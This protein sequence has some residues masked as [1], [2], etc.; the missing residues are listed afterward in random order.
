MGQSLLKPARGSALGK[1]AL[2]GLVTYG[3]GSVL[4]G[5]ANTAGK[6]ASAAGQVGTGILNTAKQA[7]L[8][9]LRGGVGGAI[10]GGL[11]GSGLLSANS[12]L[13]DVIETVAN[14]GGGKGSQTPTPTSLMP[15]ASTDEE[16]QRLQAAAGQRRPTL[17]DMYLGRYRRP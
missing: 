3:L 5:I 11:Q 1:Q 14:A 8:G 4:G 12:R 2:M 17:L 16:T 15:M 13:G 7:G 10:R 9:A 6:P